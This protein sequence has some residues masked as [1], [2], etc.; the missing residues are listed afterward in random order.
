MMHALP[1]TFMHPCVFIYIRQ[2]SVS[3]HVHEYAF[4]P[5]KQV[6]GPKLKELCTSISNIELNGASGTQMPF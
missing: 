5:S 4:K 1:V 6:P 3:T 2:D